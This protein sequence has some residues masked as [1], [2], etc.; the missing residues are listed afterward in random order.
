MLVGILWPEELPYQ[1]QFGDL[2]LPAGAPFAI[3][4]KQ[5]LSTVTTPACCYY[6]N[7]CP[8]N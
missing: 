6:K 3:D 1:F 5:A 2:P 7:V 4:L 8:R